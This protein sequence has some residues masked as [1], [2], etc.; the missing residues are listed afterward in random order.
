MKIWTSS[1]SGSEKIIGF[2][3]QTIYKGN[4][5]QNDIEACLSDL[6]MHVIPKGFI[7]IPLNYIREINMQEGKNYIEVRFGNDSY[8]NYRIKNE[9]VRNEIF[10]YLRFNI[11]NNKFSIDRFSRLRAGKKP[12]IALVVV[13]LLFLWTLS[14]AIGIARG[15]EYEIVGHKN[16]IAGIV[17]LLAGMGVKKVTLLFSSFLAIA[18]FSFFAKTRNPPVI[19][20]LTIIH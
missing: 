13:F 8:Q 14:I 3:N 1:E 5:R 15:D 16:S 9:H 20:R 7:G 4:P 10:E 12:L 11:V 6:K 18:F 17:L 2:F 19:K